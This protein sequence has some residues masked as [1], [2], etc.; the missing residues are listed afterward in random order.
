[1]LQTFVSNLLNV[2]VVAATGIGLI[3]RLATGAPATTPAVQ[4][5]DSAKQ[6][7][8]NADFG[9][10]TR[11]SGSLLARGAVTFTTLASCTN[12]QTAAN[13]LIS[14]NNALYLASS[15]GSLRN[16]FD[17]IYFRS[18]TGS[19]AS[20]FRNIFLASST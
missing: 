1:M 18:S 19:L 15:T 11:Q 4:I 3:F 2:I 7:V 17:N 20:A 14:C 10:N 12:L 5:Q 8:Y 13:G 9:G 6:D 16:L